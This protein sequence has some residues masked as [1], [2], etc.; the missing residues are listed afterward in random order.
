[1]LI[2]LRQFLWPFYTAM[3]ALGLQNYYR[4]KAEGP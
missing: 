3:R 4:A 1:M 2:T